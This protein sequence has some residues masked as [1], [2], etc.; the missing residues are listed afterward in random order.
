MVGCLGGWVV[1]WG[2]V[3]IKDHLSPAK[4][5]L[6]LS[7]AIWH[8]VCSDTVVLSIFSIPFFPPEVHLTTIQ[9]PVNIN[10]IV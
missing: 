8:H 7:L 3:N 1:G 4:L 5:E 9:M 2:Q 6:G 10:R